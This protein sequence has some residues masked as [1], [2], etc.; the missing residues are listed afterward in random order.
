MEKYTIPE[1]T[2]DTDWLHI[3]GQAKAPMKQAF[4]PVKPKQVSPGR[5]ECGKFRLVE[6]NKK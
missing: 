4:H 3:T 5:K 1:L 2:S 6:L